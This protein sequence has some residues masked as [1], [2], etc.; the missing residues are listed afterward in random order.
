MVNPQNIS[1]GYINTVLASMLE[2]SES[3]EEGKVK[4][5]DGVSSVKE[6]ELENSAF[7]YQFMP[8]A[9]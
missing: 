9:Y 6:T 5:A 7:Q 3:S 8:G 2:R 1:L 4:V